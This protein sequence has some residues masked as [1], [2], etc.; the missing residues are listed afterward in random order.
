MKLLVFYL[1]DG[2]TVSVKVAESHECVTRAFHTAVYEVTADRS[3]TLKGH[4]VVHEN[5]RPQVLNPEQVCRIEL[6]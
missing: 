6:R 5:G 1:A 3:R 4:W 2:N